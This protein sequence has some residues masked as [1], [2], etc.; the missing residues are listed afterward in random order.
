MYVIA[1]LGDGLAVSGTVDGTLVLW[2]V[3]DQ[4]LVGSLS[5]PVLSRRHRREATFGGIAHRGKVCIFITAG[6][7]ELIKNTFAFFRASVCGLFMWSDR[8]KVAHH[9]F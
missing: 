9:A 4:G 2:S 3:V 8:D 1:V 5:D 7:L 6:A